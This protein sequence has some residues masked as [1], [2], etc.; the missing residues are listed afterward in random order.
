MS[1]RD[2]LPIPHRQ[3]V[4]LTTYDA[5]DPE[6][7]TRRS[8]P[9]SH[10][11]ARPTCSWSCC[12]DAAS[13]PRR[14][15]AARARRRT[16]SDSPQPACATTAS[17]PPRCARRRARPCS[18]GAT[19]TRSAWAG[20]PR[21][22]LGAGLQLAAPN[23]AA[24]LAETLK[25][26]GYSTAQFGKC[27]EVPVWQTARWGRSN[28]PSGGSGFEHFYGF[29]GGETNQSAPAN[30]R[31]GPSRSSRLDAGGGL[32]LHRG[33]HPQGDRLGPPAQGSSRQAVLR[34]LRAGAT[35]AAHHVPKEWAD[36]YRGQFD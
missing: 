28:W 34:V 8:S 13:A 5:K 36:K 14:P 24:P 1:S 26:N 17:T 21:S 10:P 35:H 25:L 11:P 33:P 23:T 22:R 20:S 29:L 7:R 6:R 9:C 19:T 16:S 30:V 12:D 4:G 27:H 31:R 18:P 3:H 2:V 32:P 15:S